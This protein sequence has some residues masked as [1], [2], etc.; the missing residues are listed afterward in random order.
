MV[1]YSPLIPLELKVLWIDVCEVIWVA[2]LSS[3]NAGADNDSERAPLVENEDSKLPSSELE[4]VDLELGNRV[5]TPYSKFKKSRGYGRMKALS[6]DFQDNEYT[7]V[8]G[9][10]DVETSPG[11]SYAPF[12]TPKSS[13]YAK[14]RAFSC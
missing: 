5:A 8:A 10:D 12:R 2:I 7:D 4:E 14:T 1:S 9:E 3:I 11:T 6:I 13:K